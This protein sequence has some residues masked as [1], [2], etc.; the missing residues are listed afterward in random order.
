MLILAVDT[1]TTGTDAHHGCKPFIVS[2]CNEEQT[3]LW[4][5][6]VNP[7]SRQVFWEDEDLEEI[8]TLL[9]LADI[10][11]FHNT[12]FDMRM[13][14][15]I[16]I[17]I[18]HLWVKVH[19]TLIASHLVCSGD[20]HGLKDLA[21][22]YLH[23]W[24]DDE[25]TLDIAVQ[26]TR[27]NNKDYRIAKEGDP[28]FPGLK[29][30]T[31][32]WFKMDMWLAMDECITYALG[33]VERTWLLWREFKA[34]ILEENLW[35]LYLTRRK[36]LRITYDMETEGIY[37]Y[38]EKAQKFLNS[39]DR[40]R[41]ELR[42]QIKKEAGID[43]KLDLSKKVHLSSLIHN[44][45]KIPVDRKTASGMPSMTKE[46]INYYQTKYDH[47]ALETLKEYRKLETKDNYIT[48]YMNWCDEN[49]LIHSK[50]NITGT[51][52]TRQ[53]SNSPNM[54]N[55]DRTSRMFFGPP[56]G[57]IWLDIDLKNIELCIWAHETGNK[58]LIEAFAKGISIHH[59]IV[60]TLYD[61]I[62][63]FGSKKQKEEITLFKTDLSAFS[64][65]KTYANNKGGTFAWIYGGSDRKIN[66]TYFD[67]N[68]RTP[69]NGTKLIK[70]R[71]PGV[72]EFIASTA[73][74]VERNSHLRTA[75]SIVCRGGYPLE[76]AMATPYKG[77]NYRIQGAAGWIITLAMIRL[78][79]DPQVR[80]HN[81]RMISQV[82][83]SL[84]L[85]IPIQP[86][87]DFIVE[88]CVHHI[89]EAGKHLVPYKASYKVKIN[90]DDKDNPLLKVIM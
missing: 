69:P 49:S 73:K 60:D 74:E 45:L 64:E 86:A 23:F 1:E 50:L 43:Y 61:T 82:H 40:K 30:T 14:E 62:V 29:G 52:E 33:D 55:I 17:K 44:Y 2:A 6:K 16:G 57:Y 3:W 68:S 85:Q 58:E 8:Q 32:R 12:T 72:E 76:V 79:E 26:T 66:Q 46:T 34:Y 47:P 22:K 11:L 13:L 7:Y 39:V 25:Q 87:L 54:Q 21:I 36:L 80:K 83:D 59:L 38:K 9:D 35:S 41:E 90:P 53:S 5:G 15:S 70:N 10:I 4:Q 48:A 89:I 81:I 88:G 75:P 20:S 63:K 18:E 27:L 37:F 51:R 28:Q 42:K 84:I 56:P 19:D 71:F 31:V 77:T 65:T 67:T 78:Y 24:D